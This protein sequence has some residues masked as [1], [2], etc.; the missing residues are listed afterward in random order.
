MCLTALLFISIPTILE[1]ARAARSA[2]KLLESLN[3]EL[4]ATLNAL[5]QTGTGLSDLADEVTDGVQSAN[6]LVKQVDQGLDEVRQQ[7]Q[8]AQITTRS[9]WVGLQTAWQ[10]LTEQSP[11][12]KRRRRPP[13]RRPSSSISQTQS[14]KP[15]SARPESSKTVPEKYSNHRSD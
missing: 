5:K 7:A 12:K 11:R 3:R 14:P 13:T 6:H 4:P 8:R 2:E 15:I 1:L 10:V 9:T